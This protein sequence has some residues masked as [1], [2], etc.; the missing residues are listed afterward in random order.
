MKIIRTLSAMLL[1]LAF[2]S[3]ASAA[4]VQVRSPDGKITVAVSVSR[5]GTPC[6]AVRWRAK[7]VLAEAPIAL[8]FAGEPSPVLRIGAVWRRQHD[9]LVIGLLGKASG[10]RDHYAET[11]IALADADPSQRRRL[12]LV[13]RAYNDGAAYRWR[14]RSPM[15]FELSSENAGFGL[16]DHALVWAMPVKGF[17][18]SYEDY[19]RPTKLNALETDK[20]VTL[21]LLFHNGDGIWGAITEAALH[22][23]AGLYLVRQ[24][25]VPGLSAR[26]S[27]RIDRPEIAVL[28]KSGMHVS[29][30]RVLMLG[31]AP[32]RL[33]ESNIVSLLNPPPDE[34][35]WSWVKPGKTSFPWWND[36]YWPSQPFTPGLNTATMNA[37]IDFDAAH[38]IQYH[39][40][41]GYQ[42][43]AWYGGP[44]IPDGTPQDLTHVVPAIDMPAVLRHARERGV[45]IRLWAHWQPLQAQLDQALTTWERWGIEGVMVDF[46]DRD[47]QQM[48]AFYDR[49]AREAARHH[50]TI[51]YHGA[52]KPTGENRTW[53]NVLTREAVRGTEYDKFAGTAPSTPEHEATIPFTRMLAGPFDVHQGGFDTVTPDR[54]VTRFTAPQVIGTRARALASYVVYDNPL[55]MIADTPDNYRNAIGLDFVTAIPTAWDETRVLAGDVGRQI[56]IARRS[57][58]EWWIGALNDGSAR[59][60]TVSL[61]SLGSGSWRGTS[62]S[63]DSIA[64]QGVQQE[65]R[66]VDLTQS[67]TLRLS[68]AG[69]FA[70]RLSPCQSEGRGGSRC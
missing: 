65:S 12:E 63:D 44:I 31:D 2:A 48:V 43:K 42:N 57:G 38:G 23:W 39:T 35:D 26:L 14:I 46:M 54:F 15:P 1:S 36:Y 18:S 33:I 8:N 30:W 53:P 16:S 64:V 37:Y 5:T 70:M 51:V 25:N 68:P 13:V 4:P 62:F 55:S 47:D 69:G 7:Q 6:W 45:K 41:D 52:Y 29:P 49:L 56:V 20:L 50:L 27:P 24:A 22:D 28:G 67:L 17:D 60:V 11:V 66:T 61:A 21:P 32:G 19:Y 9:A 10:A 58:A 3:V 40:L 34:R 59:S